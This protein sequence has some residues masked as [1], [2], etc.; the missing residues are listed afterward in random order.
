M[1]WPKRRPV[2]AW[3][4]GLLIREGSYARVINNPAPRSGAGTQ[5]LFFSRT[6]KRMLTRVV[7][8]RP[9]GRVYGGCM[10]CGGGGVH[11]CESGV[12]VPH[13]QG[14]RGRCRGRYVGPSG[15]EG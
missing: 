13:T 4:R 1:G 2:L 3:Y 15:Q 5:R 7:E 6:P 14:L 11:R 10:I 9:V 8:L 12:N